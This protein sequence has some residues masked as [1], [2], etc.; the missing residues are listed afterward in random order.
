MQQFIKVN[1][2]IFSCCLSKVLQPKPGVAAT[3]DFLV[4]RLPAK[5]KLNTMNLA[6]K[7]N[8]VTT[9][10][11]WSILVYAVDH[12]P[13]YILGAARRPTKLSRGWVPGAQSPAVADSWLSQG[14]HGLS[15]NKA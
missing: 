4:L 15:E 8:A 12:C 7:I 6:S 3:I 1:L 10:R 5:G 14:P 2:L 13:M 11:A 9:R